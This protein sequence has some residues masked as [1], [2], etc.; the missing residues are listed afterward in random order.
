M[1]LWVQLI[2]NKNLSS[3]NPKTWLHLKRIVRFGD[4]DAAG[5]IHFYQLLHWCHEGW[6]ESIELYGLSAKRIFPNINHLDDKVSILLPIVRCEA[7]FFLPIQ[8]GDQLS[9]QLSPRRIDQGSFSVQTLFKRDNLDVG[10]GIIFHK[11]I[12]SNTRKVCPLPED[13]ERWLE[14]SSLTLGVTPV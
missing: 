3:I 6:E 12:N 13:I 9:L 1:S 14:S 7:N 8:T 4:T 10:V 2:A 11:S 5:V